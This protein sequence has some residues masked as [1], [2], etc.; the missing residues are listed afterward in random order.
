MKF[1][2]NK[3]NYHKNYVIYIEIYKNGSQM[4][5]INILRLENIV[6]EKIQKKLN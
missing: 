3:Y 5:L 6:K 2:K 4:N 1:N